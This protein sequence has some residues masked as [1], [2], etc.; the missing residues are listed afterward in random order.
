MLVNLRNNWFGPDASLYMV[1]KNPHKFPDIWK[2]KLP[3][4]AE[5]L[6]AD[7]SKVKAEEP[8]K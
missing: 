2:E 8:K 4:G 7:G 5:V 1:S 6:N 3:K